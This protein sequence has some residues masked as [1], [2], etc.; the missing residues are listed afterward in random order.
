MAK[1]KLRRY[2]NG[3]DESYWEGVL[4]RAKS[5]GTTEGWK[6]M[7][8]WYA[9]LGN[10]AVEHAGDILEQAGEG[11]KRSWIGGHG[12]DYLFGEGTGAKSLALLNPFNYQNES[13]WDL[14]TDPTPSLWPEAKGSKDE[15]FAYAQKHY[16]DSKYYLWYDPE[17]NEMMRMINQ[18]ADKP[19]DQSTQDILSGIMSDESIPQ[20][21][22]DNFKQFLVGHN[23]P[24][25][26]FGENPYG[27]AD[28]RQTDSWSY[29]SPTIYLPGS[30]DQ[31]KMQQMLEI[32]NEMGHVQQTH[33]MGRRNYLHTYADDFLRHDH[34]RDMYGDPSTLEWDPHSG[35][36][37]SAY[38]TQVFGKPISGNERDVYKFD[39]HGWPEDFLSDNPTLAP[40]TDTRK[41]Y[42]ENVLNWDPDDTIPGYVPPEN[43]EGD[44]VNTGI[45]PYGN[46]DY[47][48]TEEYIPDHSLD[49][50]PQSR[51]KMGG[52]KGCYECGGY[53]EGGGYVP[54]MPDTQYLEGGVATK[55]PGGAT[56]FTG[57]THEK[58]GIILDEYTEVED[59]ETMDKVRGQDYFFS[60][61][62]KLGGRT[63]ADRHIQL[64][65]AGAGQKEIDELADIQEK[66]AG[67]DKYDLGGERKKYVHG[68]PHGQGQERLLELFST[69]A[70]KGLIEE[71]VQPL[72]QSFVPKGYKV[73]EAHIGKDAVN[74]IAPNGKKQKFFLGDLNA[75]NAENMLTKM[76]AF[77]VNTGGTMED[78]TIFR[79]DQPE[80]VESDTPINE[81][82][83]V[84][85]EVI[86]ED[87]VVIDPP[88]PP[89]PPGPV[90]Q[91]PVDPLFPR[92]GEITGMEGF[93]Y[94]ED[95]P[96]FQ[97]SLQYGD[98][99]I[100]LNDPEF[101]ES[102]EN[103]GGLDNFMDTWYKNADPEV[104]ANADIKGPEELFANPTTDDRGRVVY[105]AWEAY[106]N[107][108]NEKYPDLDLYVDGQPG[109]QTF[110]TGQIFQEMQDPTP[111]PIPEPDLS[112]YQLDAPFFDS[113]NIYD[114]GILDEIEDASYYQNPFD[115]DATRW[116]RGPEDEFVPP[117][118]DGG[119]GGDGGDGSSKTWN[120]P[121][122]RFPWDEVLGIGAA[123][124]QLIPAWMA[125]KEKPD[126]MGAPGRLGTTHLER[127]AFNDALA[128]NAAN[129]RG[130]SRFIEQSGLGPSGIANKMASWRTKQEGDMKV[131]AEEARQNAAIANQEAQINVNSRLHNI[132]NRMYVDEFNRAADAA[133]K[134]RRLMAVQNAV[135]TLA[136]M[137]R[138]RMMYKAQKN[139]ATAISGQTGVNERFQQMLDFNRA[140]PHLMPGSADYNNA[141]NEYLLQEAD[142]N[143]YYQ[144]EIIENQNPPPSDE[145]QTGDPFY[146]MGGRRYDNGGFPTDTTQVNTPVV[147]FVAPTTDIHTDN[148]QKLYNPEYRCDPGSPCFDFFKNR[149]KMMIEGDPSIK[150]KIQ[151]TLEMKDPDMMYLNPNY[152]NI[153]RGGGRRIKRKKQIYG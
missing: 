113:P 117:V 103:M 78:G 150:S 27:Q 5:L 135:Q 101:V 61:H 122:K 109:E 42:Y 132:K 107:A 62:L 88:P 54:F 2:K 98:R 8:K 87:P 92:R 79:Q 144:N 128:A 95:I 82:E 77:I 136:G 149:K 45:G 134:D 119:D 115:P 65:N 25:I 86:V 126:Y 81:E 94:S 84:E 18:T 143:A 58:G 67:R 118:D 96:N 89:P 120:D 93:K 99:T 125:F 34:Q 74:I 153:R 127:V 38:E 139:M 51:Y 12:L 24:R 48:H 49:Y 85:E 104:L 33:E 83:M 11:Y 29:A 110:S 23:M 10:T 76:G 133:T 106:Q 6:D 55:L 116:Q 75:N 37:R 121:K 63:F 30:Q 80:I 47:S 69:V 46:L 16:P 111:E 53:F 59:G 108:W 4:R 151:D 28:R 41:W 70:E 141:F 123:A 147:D 44:N 52:E 114:Q 91:G 140:N 26:V 112:G 102:I 3:G 22:R 40:G 60:N 97:G 15:A 137:N 90:N 124:A 7:G 145:E 36:Y 31:S 43:T 21:Y 72:L 152:M 130:M 73:E 148:L 39:V 35:K 20:L 100:Y 68:G 64:L 138:D 13:V 14:V 50:D 9:G 19:W 142:P 1:K 17:K 32:I 57:R 105:P 129:Y 131:E 56:K 146:R 71:R 66:I